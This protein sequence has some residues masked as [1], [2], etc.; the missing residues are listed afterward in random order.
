MASGSLAVNPIRPLSHL[1]VQ[2]RGYFCLQPIAVCPKRVPVPLKWRLERFTREG[3]PRN[4]H[5]HESDVRR[6]KLIGD[7]TRFRSLAYRWH[8]NRKR[9]R[10]TFGSKDGRLG[11]A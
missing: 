2:V 5:E 4:G 3:P 6:W 8:E 11:N 7:G 1:S 10:A 9:M